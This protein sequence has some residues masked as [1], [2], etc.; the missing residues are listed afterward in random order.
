MIAP[1]NRLLVWFAIVGVP[2][3]ALAGIVPSAL[4]PSVALIAAFGAVAVWDAVRSRRAF[5]G[6]ELVAPPVSRM[7]I[8][9]PGQIELR[10]R[11][12]M[13]RRRLLRVAVP[14][15]SGFATPADDLDVL[16]PAE[17][18]WARLPW[19]C[20]P[21]KRGAF[22]VKSAHLESPSPLGLW[23]ARLHVPLDAEIRV[24]PDMRA[25]RQA[26]ALLLRGA[27]GAQAQRQV[28]KGREFEKL[29]DYVPGDG[30]EDIHW[31]ATARRGRPITKVFQVE[32]TQEVYVAIDT[33]RLSA[34]EDAI[35]RHISTALLIGM[36][37]QQQGDLFGLLSFSDRVDRFVRARS[38]A[39]HYHAC[40][41]AIYALQPRAV[42]PDFDEVCSFIRLR[43]RRR[44][45][46]IVLT[47]LDDPLL[48]ENF[49]RNIDI[50]ARQHLVLV[51]MVNPAGVAPMFTGSD[52]TAVDQLYDKLAGH[53]RWHN[54]EQ[55]GR[56]LHR[57]G[58]KLAI[59]DGGQM[60]L[61]LVSD[62]LAIKNRQLL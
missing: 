58:V 22:S 24:Y 29:R 62:Y 55:L 19:A 26:L 44:A 17:A 49:L 51:G 7:A 11:N 52:V 33:S 37:A 47:A 3:A 1:R 27:S 8:D 36:A 45:L 18:E 53:L 42:N 39:S 28:G 12:G 50:I 38:G 4:V 25:E 15:P 32:R 41:D 56:Q 31:K 59:S 30:L 34:R 40:R 43:L 14:L 57:R 13:R 46:V 2:F 9:R 20:T 54:L 48:A 5:E 60:A 6:I 61:R 16:L 23:N 35:E 10:V 21:E